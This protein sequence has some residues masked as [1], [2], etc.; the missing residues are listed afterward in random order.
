MKSCKSTCETKN[1]LLSKHGEDEALGERRGTK[2][3]SIQK[4]PEEC[5][6]TVR[7]LETGIVKFRYGNDGEYFIHLQVY[8]SSLYVYIWEFIVLI[9]RDEYINE[10]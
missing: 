1:P 4:Q 2:A 7:F 3:D 6:K 8:S 5:N 9:H 10:N